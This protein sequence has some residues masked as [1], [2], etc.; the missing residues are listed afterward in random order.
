MAVAG[1]RQNGSTQPDET[2]SARPEMECT[3]DH[4]AGAS[5][6]GAS[7]PTMFISLTQ[8][9]MP[10]RLVRLIIGLGLYGI[11]IG[12]M[13]QSGL[14]VPPW[15]VLHQGLARHLGGSIGL[16][17]I[18]VGLIVLIPWIP[19]HQPY[20]IGT[21]LNAIMIGT[22]IDLTIA[23]VPAPVDRVQAWAFLLGGILMIGVTSG[24]YIGANLGPGPRD[25]LM[26]G[27]ARKGPSIRLVRSVLEITV[28]V[29]GII[30]GGTFGVGTVLFALGIG[31][32]IHYFLPRLTL[33]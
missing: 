1:W 19:L 12:F 2:S 30:L 23:R 16:W 11:G 24:L 10:T 9:R 3:L 32:L 21:I 17:S 29:T 20:G 15:D 4:R 26:T 31:P 18:L 13:N 7:V 28:L 27:I 33:R 5:R 22:F 6:T 14:G 25:G 8:S